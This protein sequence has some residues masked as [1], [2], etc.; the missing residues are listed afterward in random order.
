MTPADTADSTWGAWEWVP[1]GA[2]NMTL[3]GPLHPGDYE[4]R[5]HANYPRILVNIVHR[6]AITVSY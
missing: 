4:I 1:E 2:R 5:L 6:V 3:L